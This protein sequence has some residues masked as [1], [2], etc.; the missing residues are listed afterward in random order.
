MESRILRIGLCWSLATLLSMAAAP[1][2][3]GVAWDSYPAVYDL[4]EW[5]LDWSPTHGLTIEAHRVVRVNRSSG[6]VAGQIRIWDTFFQRLKSF[7]GSVRDTLGRVLYTA[8]LNDVRSIAPFSEFRLY[9]G[10]VVRTVD[11][12]APQAPYIFEARWVVEIDNPFFWPDWILGDGFPRRR[13]VYRVAVPPGQGV[14]FKQVLPELSKKFEK[15]ARREVT[16][17]ELRDWVIP[18]ISAENH[19]I[20]PLLYVAPEE[21]RVGSVKGRTDSWDALGRWYWALTANRL[22]LSKDQMKDVNKRLSEV[23]GARAQAAALKDWVSDDWRYVAIEVGLGGWTPHR[24]Q[25][26][27]ANRYGDCKDLVFLWVAMMR[28]RGLEAYPALIRARNPLPIDVGFPKDWFD[29]VMAVAI[30]DGDTL[31]VDPSDPRYRLGTLPPSCEAR[32][33]LVVGEFGGRLL[34]TP[35]RSGDE[36]RQVVRCTGALDERGN[37]EFNVVIT[38]KGHFAQMLPFHGNLDPQGKVA[39]VLGVAPPAIKGTLDDI[40][41]L[42]SDEVALHLKGRIIGWAVAG[43]KRMV[44]RPRLGGWMAT[45]TLLGRPNPGYVEFPEDIYDTLVIDF[46]AGWIPELWPSAPDDSSAGGL[47]HERCDFTR[48]QMTLSRRLKWDRSDRSD[49]ERMASARLRGDYRAAANAEWVFRKA[50]GESRA[51]SSN[52]TNG[53][54][55]SLDTAG[56]RT[57]GGP[58]RHNR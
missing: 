37:L 29:H 39:V 57:G 55:D 2:R 35:S 24:A 34:Q 8:G 30:I 44:V 28:E 14:H 53:G 27:Y 21:F 13:A 58:G 17:W 32:W 50:E 49:E 11:L 26:V 7:E 46:P 42:S 20:T 10:D 22:G 16:T 54:S 47:F 41:V 56:A 52:G 18:Q 25:E 12:A 43:P 40:N 51:D 36:N 4:D 9:S 3:S 33:A 23:V 15:Q 48:G 38:A 19:T 1:A 31:W 5:S 45:D 6:S